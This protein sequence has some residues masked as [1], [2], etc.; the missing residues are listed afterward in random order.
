[1]PRTRGLPVPTGKWP[2]DQRHENR[3]K[4]EIKTEIKSD[5]KLTTK[6]SVLFLIRFRAKLTNLNFIPV[7][8]RIKNICFGLI[9]FSDYIFISFQ[10]LIRSSSNIK[11][12]I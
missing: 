5:E 4:T 9:Y 8:H 1:M 12:N 6:I 2:H 3:I 11:E 7:G 10:I